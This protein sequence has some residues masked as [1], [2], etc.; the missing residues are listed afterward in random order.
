MKPPSMAPFFALTYQA[1]TDV[2]RERGYAL[3]LHGTMDRDLDL[4]AVPWTEAAI[5]AAELAR[6]V[7]EHIG[8]WKIG[9]NG[10]SLQQT[11]EL[12]MNGPVPKPHGR[13]VWTILYGSTWI[14]L[15]VVPRGQA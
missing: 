13:L 15:S 14:D 12:M 11:A 8:W 7:G 4:V 2:C 10:H 5:S 9:P 6:A 3:A 1:L